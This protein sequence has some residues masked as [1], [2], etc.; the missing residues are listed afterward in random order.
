M[1]NFTFSGVIEGFELNPREE[2]VKVNGKEYRMYDAYIIAGAL[3]EIGQTMC[4]PTNNPDQVA[5]ELA[6]C[7][8][9]STEIAIADWV[10]NRRANGV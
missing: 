4:P 7:Y 8:G 3:V 10:R 1:Y 2:I 9:G 5:T 6:H